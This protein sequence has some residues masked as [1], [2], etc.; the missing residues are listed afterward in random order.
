MIDDDSVLVD[1]G[2]GPRRV[3]LG[4]YLDPEAEMRAIAGE[5]A[6]I[7]R[8][9]H[10]NIDGQPMRRRFTF[11][12]DSLWWFTEL[13]LHKEQVLL[14]LFRTIA[15]LQRVIEQERPIQIDVSASGPI[16]RDLARHAAGPRRTLGFRG[17]QRAISIRF[18]VGVG[19]TG[20]QPQCSKNSITVR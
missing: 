20:T 9:R 14:T 18:L 1:T 3:R 17:A 16:V 4:D 10:L 5:Y 12:G 15:A 6:W 2:T 13:Y 19:A 8:L 11:R 7:K